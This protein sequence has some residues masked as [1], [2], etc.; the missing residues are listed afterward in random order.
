MV[1]AMDVGGNASS[2]HAEGRAARKL[3][4]DARE[5]LA[6]WFGCLPQ[7]MVFTSG[8]TEAN[9]MAL[10]GADVQ[11]LLVS[12]IEHPSVLA[13]AKS[14]GKTVEIIP[15]DSNGVV[16]LSSLEKLLAGPKALVSVMLANN[17]TGVVQPI[18]EIAVT[19]HKAGSLLHVDGVQGVAN[20]K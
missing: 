20:C 2:V 7:M 16:D 11:R 18:A 4:D 13:A 19:V 3:M 14:S 15:V 6:F 10:R 12:G 5:K 17:E 9:N 1:A 8:G